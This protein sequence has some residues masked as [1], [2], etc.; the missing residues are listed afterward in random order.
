MTSI[1]PKYE[2]K[3]EKARKMFNRK[4]KDF[5]NNGS[6]AIEYFAAQ[7]LKYERIS[8]EQPQSVAKHRARYAHNAATYGINLAFGTDLAK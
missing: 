1:Y 8:K 4:M 6:K 2:S 7:A 5:D 3:W